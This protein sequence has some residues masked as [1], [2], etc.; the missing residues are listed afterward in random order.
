MIYAM[1]I[2]AVAAYFGL[3]VGWLSAIYDPQDFNEA[4]YDWTDGVTI[5]FLPF[6]QVALGFFAACQLVRYWCRRKQ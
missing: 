4:Y 5:L 1:I 6:I 3:I 2:A